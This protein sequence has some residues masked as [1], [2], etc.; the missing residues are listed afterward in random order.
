MLYKFIASRSDLQRQ[1]TFVDKSEIFKKLGYRS[2]TIQ[3]EHLHNGC[4]IGEC[5]GMNMMRANSSTIST[6]ASL[7]KRHG[8]LRFCVGYTPRGNR[9]DAGRW[10]Q[11]SEESG[12]AMLLSSDGFY[13]GARLFELYDADGAAALKRATGCLPSSLGNASSDLRW[14]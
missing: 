5:F 8:L 13:Q 12:V 4:S 10:L 14:A 2:S 3:Y 7:Y 9:F 6:V 11:F 1:H